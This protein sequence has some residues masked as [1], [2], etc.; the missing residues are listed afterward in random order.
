MELWET[1]V[2]EIKGEKRRKEEKSKYRGGGLEVFTDSTT[3]YR[4]KCVYFYST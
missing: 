1:E 2:K 3:K 4:T